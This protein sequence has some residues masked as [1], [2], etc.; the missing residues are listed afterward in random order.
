[1]VGIDTLAQS[2]DIRSAYKAVVRYIERMGDQLSAEQQEAANE[3]KR[4][5]K[6]LENDSNRIVKINNALLDAESP[7]IRF[8]DSTGTIT[9]D[10]KGAS[11]SLKLKRADPEIPVKIDQSSTMGAYVAGRSENDSDQSD[12]LKMI[13]EQ[14][15]EGFYNNAFRITKLVQ[16]IINKRKYDCREITIVRNKLVEHPDTGTIY[17]FGYS[18]N[19]PVVKPIHRGKKTWTDAGLV[20]NTNALA[21]SLMAAFSDDA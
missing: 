20:P 19:G 6:R 15:L 8:D 3:L 11:Q 14:M 2:P 16:V 17:S 10:F 9:F 4:R 5:L 21:Y 1:M 12:E 13:M 7:K 18:S